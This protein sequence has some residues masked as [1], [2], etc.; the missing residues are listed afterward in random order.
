M[1]DFSFGDGLNVAKGTWLCVPQREIM[2][3]PAI[4]PDAQDFKGFRFVEDHEHNPHSTKTAK[5]ADIHTF[6]PL[7]G[8]GKHAW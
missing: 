6:Y 1:K 3:D 5:F 2:R 4:Y 8:L 7:W